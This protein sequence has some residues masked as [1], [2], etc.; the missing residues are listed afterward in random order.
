MET[1]NILDQHLELPGATW[2]SDERDMMQQMTEIITKVSAFVHGY[3]AFVG[4]ERQIAVQIE[5]H[6]DHEQWQ[7]M[8]DENTHSPADNSG[9]LNY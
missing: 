3:G 4:I 8:K 2:D 9:N 5:L 7:S 6:T 1:P